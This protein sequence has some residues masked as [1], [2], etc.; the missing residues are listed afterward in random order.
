MSTY[1]DEEIFNIG[2]RFREERE[3]IGVGRESLGKELLTSGRTI[4]KYE[5]NET[6]PRAHELLLFSRLGADVLYI[7]TGQ[8]QVLGVSEPAA[9][10]SVAADLATHVAVLKLSE[11][12]AALLRSVA[13]RLAQ[14]K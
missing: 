13:D 10:Y 8:R 6:S 3:R 11:P 12:D 14:K 2:G 1:N 5:A 4:V 9:P 7:V